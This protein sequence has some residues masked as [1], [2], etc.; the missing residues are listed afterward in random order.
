MSDGTHV[1]WDTVV[2]YEKQT[3]VR[4]ISFEIIEWS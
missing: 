3:T 2:F 1:G 4:D